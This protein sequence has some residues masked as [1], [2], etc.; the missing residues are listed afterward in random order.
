MFNAKDQN[1]NNQANVEHH[2]NL[3]DTHT[4]LRSKFENPA[5]LFKKHK[6]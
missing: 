3:F 5:K 4:F 2:N 6:N 1:N